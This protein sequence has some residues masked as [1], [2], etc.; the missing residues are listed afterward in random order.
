MN[1]PEEAVEKEVVKRIAERYKQRTGNI[2]EIGNIEKIVGNLFHEIKQEFELLLRQRDEEID[3]FDRAN[4]DL[5]QKIL[6]LQHEKF[7]LISELQQYRER[8]KVMIACADNQLTDTQNMLRE[9]EVVFAM[10]LSVV[11][12]KINEAAWGE[13][14]AFSIYTDICKFHSTIHS[15]ASEKP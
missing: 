4:D 8:E 9:N 5:Y 10:R 1:T 6:K 13:K 2:N 14:V 12:D 15:L 11:K 3:K 7:V